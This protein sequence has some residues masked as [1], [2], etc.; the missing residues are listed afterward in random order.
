MWTQPLVVTG[1]GPCGHA[2]YPNV[3]GG[4]DLA[5]NTVARGLTCHLLN[6]RPTRPHIIHILVICVMDNLVGNMN[7]R[8][9]KLMDLLHSQLLTCTM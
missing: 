4:Q 7:V 9:G 3:I 5:L 1:Q 8:S 6:P 2:T